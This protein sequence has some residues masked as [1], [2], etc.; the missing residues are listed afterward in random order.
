METSTDLLQQQ[1]KLIAQLNN[2]AFQA[3]Q[4]E[5]KQHEQEIKFMEENKHPVIYQYYSDPSTQSSHG[6]K[7]I[8]SLH[9]YQSSSVKI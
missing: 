4:I 5:M 6:E 7:R 1:H 3:I 2:L 8:Q 9:N